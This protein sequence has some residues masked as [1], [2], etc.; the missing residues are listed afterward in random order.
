[1]GAPIKDSVAEDGY[2]FKVVYYM[3][4]DDSR[5]CNLWVTRFKQE[6]DRIR[7]ADARVPCMAGLSSQGGTLFA[8]NINSID[9]DK[10]LYEIFIYNIKTPKWYLMSQADAESVVNSARHPERYD[11]SDEDLADMDLDDAIAMAS[12]ESALAHQLIS[13]ELMRSVAN[14]GLDRLQSRRQHEETASS[15]VTR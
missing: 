4:H 7:F 6:A 5:A 3:A 1:M 11:M 13:E 2:V 12:P 14:V 10:S 15:A 9:L 8:Q